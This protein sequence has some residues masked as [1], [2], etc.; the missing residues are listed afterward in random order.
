MVVMKFG[1]SYLVAANELVAVG[2]LDLVWID[3]AHGLQI[4]Y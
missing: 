1:Y 2:H 3:F 4:L